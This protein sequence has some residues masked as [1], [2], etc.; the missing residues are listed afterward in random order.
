MHACSQQHAARAPTIGLPATGRAAMTPNT[1]QSCRNLH[2]KIAATAQGPN[3]HTVAAHHFLT[4]H[5][6]ANHRQVPRSPEHG[7]H[8]HHHNQPQKSPQAHALLCERTC[9]GAAPRRAAPHA[10]DRRPA[11]ALRVG[12]AAEAQLVDVVAAAAT[13]H[14]SLTTCLHLLVA[15]AGVRVVC[16]VFQMK[17]QAFV[18]W[19]G[20]HQDHPTKHEASTTAI[21]SNQAHRQPH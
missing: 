10:R 2:H 9:A 13:E 16:F 15:P 3:T 8:R 12:P 5:G 4:A 20:V 1:I 21:A 19:C 6:T 18:W 17:S 11:A 14:H 7:L